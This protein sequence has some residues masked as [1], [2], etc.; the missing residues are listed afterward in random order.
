MRGL[1]APCGDA[2]GARDHQNRQQDGRISP[3]SKALSP[4]VYSL[5]L[6]VLSAAVA[7]GGVAGGLA[8]RR[9]G[10]GG[11]MISRGVV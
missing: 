2:E 3:G 8:G 7:G 1:A 9:S 5:A 10:A 11:P 6:A 4:L